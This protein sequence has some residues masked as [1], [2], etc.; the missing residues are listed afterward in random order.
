M[1]LHT[2]V[3]EYDILQAQ[4]REVNFGNSVL[5]TDNIA[6]QSFSTDLNNY[7]RRTQLCQF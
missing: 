3:N 7:L 5:Q 4:E 1:I 2:I 6:E